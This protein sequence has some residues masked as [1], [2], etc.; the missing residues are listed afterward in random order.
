MSYTSEL[1]EL[2]VKD[3]RF[4]NFCKFCI[5]VYDIF[6]ELQDANQLFNEGL[7]TYYCINATPNCFLF[8]FMNIPDIFD[9]AIKRDIAYDDILEKQN[10]LRKQVTIKGNNIDNMDLYEFGYKFTDFLSETYGD[11]YLI[12]VL[13]RIISSD[14][15]IYSYDLLKC[16]SEE[17]HKLIHDK[18][19]YD[20]MFLNLLFKIDRIMP[21]LLK[22]R[23]NAYKSEKLF[24]IITNH[25]PPK[26][27]MTDDELFA[28]LF[29][30]FF[31]HP[32]VIE[33][34]EKLLDRKLSNTDIV[35]ALQFSQMQRIGKADELLF[36]H[37]QFMASIENDL[38]EKVKER[39]IFITKSDKYAEEQFAS[40]YY[41]MKTIVK[42]SEGEL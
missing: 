41:G 13:L 22:E 19:S 4:V 31:T 5:R 33:E 9:L 1:D 25:V 40:T 36:E 7:A 35:V 8:S 29:Q 30:R 14:L 2:L 10:E 42:L 32:C 17:R 38:L 37:N 21:I 39:S 23:M 15:S 12:L 34:I 20:T 3:T 6:L 16:N 18:F 26:K 24:N 27:K 11:N 28:I